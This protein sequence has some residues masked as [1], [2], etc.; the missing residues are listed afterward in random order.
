MIDYTV[1]DRLAVIRLSAPPANVL[2]FALLESLRAAVRRAADDPAVDGIVLTGGD[3]IFSAGADLSIFQAIR[4]GNDSIRASQVFQEAFQEIEDG[5]KPVVAAVAGHVLGGALELAMAC[6]YRV[7]A[8]G[9]RFSMPEVNLGI[10]PGAGGTQRLPRLVGVE[11]A[12][13]M[14]LSGRPIDCQ[15]AQDQ[16]LIDT[17]C[18]ADELLA[19]SKSLL[20]SAWVADPATAPRTGQ[21][22]AKLGDAQSNQAAFEKADQRAVA[23]RTEIIAPQVI[24]AAVRTGVEESFAAGLRAEQTGFRDCMATLAAQNKIY[25]LCASQQTAKLV[26]IESAAPA[27]IQR[28]AVLGMGTMGAGIAQALLAAGIDVVAC[29]QS[30]QALQAGVARIRASLD[31]RVAQ[32]KQTAAQ[33][34]AALGRLTPTTDV[35][36]MADAELVVEAIYEDTAIK[37]AAL[38]QIEAVCSPET[39]IGTNTSTISL[40]QLA[41]AMVRPGQLVGLHFFHPAQQMPLVEVIRT[42]RA[43]RDG[44]PHAEREEYS[45]R[46]EVVATAMALTKAMRKTPVLVNNREGFLVS[47]LFVPYLKEA[48]W[49]LEEG[50]E[51]EAID[52]AATAFGFAMGPLRLIDMSGLD[53]LVLTDRILQT[54]FPYHGELS[55]IARELVER[56]HLGQKTTAGVYR[57]LSGDR[58]PRHHDATA[59]IIAA[60]RRPD[61]AVPDEHEIVRRLMLRMVAEAF[62]VLEE[63][64]VQRPADVD[65]AMVLGIG[66]GDFRGGVL[67]YACDLGLGAVLEQ[68]REYSNLYGPRFAPCRFLEAAAADPHVLTL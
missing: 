55:R 64:L 68:L 65:V 20:C 58:T 10:N 49:L 27:K 48:F 21:L 63:G 51:P 8:A 37:Q 1:S 12:L 35:Q 26:D 33:A 54:A 9:S 32:G 29:D 7:A 24:L 13:D 52:R 5:P 47:R 45:T 2:S 59:A 67:K 46:P 40:D 56:G 34:A 66:L 41:A 6:H 4:C 44:I 14:L 43:P 18:P 36:R 15:Q 16:G 25:V 31:R 19:V 57:Y 62:R 22:I 38:A 50:A 42:R 11:T 60:A 28:A 23:G 3:K 61:S 17:V 53:I 39:I 30:D